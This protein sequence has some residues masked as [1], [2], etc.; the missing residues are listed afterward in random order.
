MVK[1]KAGNIENRNHHVN[2]KPGTIVTPRMVLSQVRLYNRSGALNGHLYGA[3][4]GAIREYRTT[5]RQDKYAEY[6]LA[7]CAHYVGDLSQPLHNTL[8]ND[9]NKRNHVATDAVINGEV[10][11]KLPLIEVY[12]IVIQSEDDLAQ[13]VARIANL[14][15]NL[16]YQLEKEGRMI[17]RQEAYVQIGHSASLFRG[18]LRWLGK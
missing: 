9:Y 3:I 18:I 13:E 7:F 2:N 12:P 8:Y 11:Y 1:L 14:S 17:S 10:L 5:T 4:L 16:G 6:H 15:L